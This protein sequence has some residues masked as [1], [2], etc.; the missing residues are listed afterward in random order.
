MTHR[1]P[2]G[3]DPRPAPAGRPVGGERPPAGGHEATTELRGALPDQAA[4]MG[5]LTTPCDLGLPLLSVAGA[6]AGRPAGRN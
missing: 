3:R 6:P 1:R 5:V 2:G 4:L